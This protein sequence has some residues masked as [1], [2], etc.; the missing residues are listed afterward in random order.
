M[1]GVLMAIAKGGVAVAVAGLV[2][3]CGSA[4]E[5]PQKISLDTRR[6]EL[7]QI[8]VGEGAVWVRNYSDGTIWRIDSESGKVTAKTVV[9][10]NGCCL[11]VGEGGVWA[12]VVGA[13][14][15]VRL[16]P[17][18][19]RLVKR[20]KVG[21]YPELLTVAFGAVW[22]SNH[23]DG[24]VSRIDPATSSVVKTVRVSDWGSS[25]PQAIVGA[26]GAIWVAVPRDFAVYR[27]DPSTNKVVAKIATATGGCGS[28]AGDAHSV[29]FTGGG[30]APYLEHIA[31][32][33][34]K[35][36][37]RLERKKRVGRP[38]GRLRFRLGNNLTRTGSDRH[39]DKQGRRAA[40]IPRPR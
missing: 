40:A 2:A 10:P 8:A 30:C 38:R 11:A 27:I 21:D 17:R 19:A 20:I 36:V 15:V 32:G 39:V 31:P 35:V 6:S 24:T 29:W 13:E 34:N 14:V 16:D 26:A 22:V 4:T 7:A 3:G 28:A 1:R 23:H 5:S 37:A 9:G 12:T 18:T 25:G 33:T